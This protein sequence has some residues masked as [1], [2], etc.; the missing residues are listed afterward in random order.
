MKV[1]IE[2]AIFRLRKDIKAQADRLGDNV[3][4]SFASDINA[5]LDDH[6][7]LKGANEALNEQLKRIIED[8]D[9]MTD[10]Y[11]K[12][13]GRMRDKVDALRE[14]IADLKAENDNLE[15]AISRKGE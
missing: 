10:A 15:R 8:R 1:K 3:T 2:R 6:A 12:L 11:N 5:L 7:R 13:E 9:R 4:L 14:K